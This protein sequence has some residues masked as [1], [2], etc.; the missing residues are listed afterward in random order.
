MANW[1]IG[2]IR[3]HRASRRDAPAVRPI[4][5]TWALLCLTLLLVALAIAPGAGRAVPF[6]GGHHGQQQAGR[7]R[8]GI[9]VTGDITTLGPTLNLRMGHPG[10]DASFII[11]GRALHTG[12][13]HCLARC[14][15]TPPTNSPLLAVDAGAR[16]TIHGALPLPTGARIV[17][18]VNHP[19]LPTLGSG[20]LICKG[21]LTA[22]NSGV[23]LTIVGTPAMLPIPLVAADLII[24]KI[25]AGPL[26]AGTMLDV[27]AKRIALIRRPKQ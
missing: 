27:T 19:A 9:H 2:I 8:P 24:G 23:I 18:A 15:L 14:D 6:E 11:T 17:I 1:R 10:A 20:L 3:E 22:P 5:G 13:T 25:I 12:S 21:V 7:D 16:M 4:K 26:P